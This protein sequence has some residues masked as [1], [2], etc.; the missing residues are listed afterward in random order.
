MRTATKSAKSPGA[1][2]RSRAALTPEGRESQLVSLATDLAEQ[3]LMN[4]TASAQVI[5]HYLKLGT[6]KAKVELELLE[7]QKAMVDAKTDSYQSNKRMEEIMINAM[8]AMKRYSMAG[9]D[10]A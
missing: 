8:E 9:N 4:G 2:R 3:Q 1:S 7:K 10:E 5:V 6:M